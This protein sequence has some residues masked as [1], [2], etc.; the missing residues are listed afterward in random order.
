MWGLIPPSWYG[1]YVLHASGWLLPAR[2]H[3]E[4]WC[5][6]TGAGMQTACVQHSLSD[7]SNNTGR[8]LFYAC[9]TFVW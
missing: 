9:G 2:W 7:S 3:W 1:V 8:R 5:Q 4:P 6:G